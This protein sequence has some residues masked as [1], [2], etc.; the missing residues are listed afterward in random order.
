MKNYIIFLIIII[1]STN[2]ANAAK[3]TYKK[4][5]KKIVKELILIP[6]K[7][8]L[9][10]KNKIQSNEIILN[11]IIKVKPAVTTALTEPT[12]PTPVTTP[13]IQQ[14]IS[15]SDVVQ[16]PVIQPVPVA[17]PEPT[18]QAPQ[19]LING[20]CI[21]PEPTCVAPQTLVNGACVT[22]APTCIAPQILVNGACVT[23]IPTCIAP[24]KLVNGACV[25]PAP[26]CVAPQKLVNGVCVTPIPTCIAPQ[27]LVNGAC[28]NPGP[29]PLM[30][31]GSV[32]YPTAIGIFNNTTDN[33]TITNISLFEGSSYFDITNSQA[34]TISNS[35][36]QKNSDCVAGYCQI[37]V[38]NVPGNNQCTR[39]LMPNDYWK[40]AYTTSSND[41]YISGFI[42]YQING[43]NYTS[44]V[45]TVNNQNAISISFN[46]DFIKII[47]WKD[48]IAPTTSLAKCSNDN[49]LIDSGACGCSNYPDSSTYTGGSCSITTL[50]QMQE[51]RQIVVRVR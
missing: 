22:P 6:K 47:E 1:L 23:P 24:Q 40:G 20:A 42:Q 48:F 3:K 44:K 15:P 7:T 10:V 5:K 37:N 12:L 39:T 19:T 14:T 46:N 16:Q 2:T 21:T 9:E 45:F 32:N 13:A 31:A 30:P 25:T 34:V 29:Q 49:P 35:A 26:T 8:P 36:C 33:I 18:C 43:T 4:P 51:P 50:D 17:A 11:P 41:L 38:G 27:T 28:V